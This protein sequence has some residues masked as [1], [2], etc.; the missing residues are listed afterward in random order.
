[1]K[2]ILAKIGQGLSGKA[3]LKPRQN[4]T[5]KSQLHGHT[6]QVLHTYIAATKKGDG[7]RVSFLENPVAH[8][9]MMGEF[10]LIINDRTPIRRGMLQ[11]ALQDQ[12]SKR[13]V[14]VLA[15]SRLY[16]HNYEALSRDWDLKDSRAVEEAY[17]YFTQRQQ[18][19]SNKLSEEEI[20]RKKRNAKKYKILK[21]NYMVLGTGRREWNKGKKM[22]GILY[23][24]PAPAQFF[25]DEMVFIA[26]D[27]AQKQFG[28]QDKLDIFDKD[29]NIVYTSKLYA[30]IATQA[31]SDL[32]F[33]QYD[34]ALWSIWL[35]KNNRNICI[36]KDALTNNEAQLLI[37][38]LLHDID[39]NSNNQEFNV[40][41]TVHKNSFDSL[42]DDISDVPIG[43]KT[44]RI[45]MSRQYKSSISRGS[46]KFAR[47]VNIRM[48]ESGSALRKREEIG[49][50]PQDLEIIDAALRTGSHINKG[51]IIFSGAPSSAKSTSLYSIFTH[52]HQD[53]DAQ[54]VTIDSSVEFEV[55]GLRQIATDDTKRAISEDKQMN[56]SKVV[57]NMLKQF[58]DALIIGEVRDDEQIRDFIKGA[59]RGRL[60]AGSMH[61]SD[62]KSIFTVLENAGLKPYQYLPVC[63]LFVHHQLVPAVCQK[64]KGTGVMS[65]N[66]EETTCD[67]CFGSGSDG[68]ELIYELAYL[69][70]KK[71]PLDAKP[72][73]EFE[74][75]IED[76]AIIFRSQE[77]IAWEKYKDGKINE[78]T[79]KYLMGENVE[80]IKTLVEEQNAKRRL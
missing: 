74:K 64:C 38:S 79:Y 12:E 54:V 32:I 48:L 19:S 49:Y 36:G 28:T 27:V 9:T 70:E 56:I 55:D 1:M 22:I 57:N 69:V 2:R 40:T 67:A 14:E 26:P 42:G 23:P 47:S 77:Q 60:L 35:R 4:V 75:L 63:R 65:E 51:C 11:E 30:Y 34:A 24:T 5:P 66:S 71:M 50:Y 53:F 80:R 72:A 10:A 37:Q 78:E 76:S 6:E 7:S 33:Y 68:K 3:L 59:A 15:D 61:T 21:K 18:D 29:R 31:C 52:L 44:F 16:Y 13:S 20:Q 73:E 58:A 25:Y 62:T 39:E 45:D 8:K 41:G 43:D 46:Q 17:L